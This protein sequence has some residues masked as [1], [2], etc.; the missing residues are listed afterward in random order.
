MNIKDIAKLAG[1]SVATVSRVINGNMN[2]KNESRKKIEAVIKENNYIPSSVGI[3][4]L[5]KKSNVIGIILPIVHSYYTERFNAILKV[6]SENNYTTIIAVSFYNENEEVK[7]LS[8]FISRQVD[9]VIFMTTKI[10][11]LH[12][13]ILE[14]YINKTPLVVID[15]DASKYGFSSIIHDDYKGAKEA[16]SY[17]ISKGHKKIAFISGGETN[18][19]SNSKRYQAYEDM[20]VSIGISQADFIVASGNYSMKSGYDAI[21]SLFANNSKIIPTAIYC[22]NDSMAIGASRRLHELGYKIPEDVSLIGTDDVEPVK[23]MCP[24][25][26]TTVKQQLTQSGEIAAELI[27]NHIKSNNLAIKTIVL[28]QNLIL[29]ES[30]KDLTNLT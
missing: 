14:K 8:D 7:A 11:Q 2:V 22:A 23:Y 4:L 30:V 20:M 27:L 5:K 18:L 15:S 13:E 12:I 25:S 29:R 10:T 9:G 3:T 24:A 19:Y 16:I 6:L 21:N 28:N 26:L 17:L 1:V